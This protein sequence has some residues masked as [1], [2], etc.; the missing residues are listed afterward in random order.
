M[1]NWRVLTLATAALL[2]EKL[3]LVVAH[4]EEHNEGP[5]EVQEGG[6]PQS[7]WGL[8]DYAAL[9]YWHVGLEILAWI[10]VLPVGK[11]HKL[12]PYEVALG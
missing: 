9:M 11:L 12:L 5:V 4:G 10:V 6:R 7:Y 3:P 2:L 8:S 1:T